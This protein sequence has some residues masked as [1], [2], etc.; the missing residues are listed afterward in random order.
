MSLSPTNTKGDY[1]YIT[2]PIYYVNDKPHIGHMY[3]SLA[4]DVL[5]RYNRLKGI[6]H[7]H[8]LTGTD[9]HGQKV[10]K[11]AQQKEMSCEAFTDQIHKNFR[12]LS[13]HMNFT[14]DD[15]IRTTQERHKRASQ[16]L[17]NRIEERGYLYLDTYKGW[18]SI[19]DEA[20]YTVKEV[21][22][23]S[24][25]NFFNTVTGAPVEWV[26]EESYFFKLNEF[27]DNLLKFYKNNSD[28]LAPEHQY[29]EV[30]NFISGGLLPLSVSRT[31]FQWG[32]ALPEE[33]LKKSLS[34]KNH[35]MY[36]WM[37]ALTNYLTGLGFPDTFYPNSAGQL[38]NPYWEEAIHIIGKDIVRFHAV[39]WLAFLMAGNIALPKRIF[40][41][42]WWTNEGKKISKSLGNTIDPY[43]LVD[44][45]SLDAVRFFMLREIVFG[46]DG[47]FSH[48]A[49]VRRLNTDLANDYG[50]L[51][52]RVFSM[53][54]NHCNNIETPSDSQLTS[55]DLQFLKQGQELFG[56]VDH[57]L[58][59]QIFHTALESIMQIVRAGNIYIDIQAPW[60]LHNSHPQR[61]KTILWVLLENI[62]KITYLFIPFMPHACEK[63]FQLFSLDEKILSLSNFWEKKYFYLFSYLSSIKEKPYPIFPKYIEKKG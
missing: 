11:A 41:H 23:D 7:V 27:Q 19:R 59:Q 45:Y 34:K 54:Y 8:F 32:I 17:W 5:A 22:K 2:T 31:G 42:G 48:S 33:S 25:G 44:K 43:A 29:N 53:I 1:Y 57:S 63:I 61:M 46:A 50:N 30:M 28:F 47:N 12:D 18:Y 39:Y 58:S 21:E 52:Q 24:Q 35:I 62:L 37:D 55:E 13:K 60:K 49:C 36:V 20:F 15:F 16:Y 38:T 14:N 51:C 56:R 9:E 40:S 3:T 4:C 26:E 6:K 10:A